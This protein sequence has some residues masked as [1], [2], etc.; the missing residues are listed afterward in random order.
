MKEI[1][2]RPRSQA[3]AAHGARL[4][5]TQ[6]P[7]AASAPPAARRI[8]PLAEM[9]ARY[10]LFAAPDLAIG[11]RGIGRESID[12]LIGT[13]VSQLLADAAFQVMVI[14]A[15][16]LE[17]ELQRGVGAEQLPVGG[18]ELSAPRA[19]RHQVAQAQGADGE[20]HGERRGD[21][22]QDDGQPLTAQ[23]ESEPTHK[24]H[25]KKA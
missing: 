7:A 6:T 5:A 15:E 10:D 11:R 24:L 21:G 20:I 3:S 18:F 8:E 12:Q 14:R 23:M 9:S 25:R 13:H 17:L 19:Q 22:S 1:V 2:W 4:A 16:S